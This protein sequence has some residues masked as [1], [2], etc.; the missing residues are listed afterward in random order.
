[1]ELTCVPNDEKVLDADLL[2]QEFSEL[3][4]IRFPLK[5]TTNDLIFMVDYNGAFYF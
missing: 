1:M 2:Q 4:D 5:I 3:V